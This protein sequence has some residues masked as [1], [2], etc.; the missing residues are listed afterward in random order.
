ML[1]IKQH[2]DLSLDVVVGGLAV[3]PRFGEITKQ[4]EADGFSLPLFHTH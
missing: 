4:I 1:A 2:Q 3:L